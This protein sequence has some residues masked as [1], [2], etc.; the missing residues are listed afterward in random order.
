MCTQLKCHSVEV[1][2][3]VNIKSSPPGNTGLYSFLHR[4]Y[5]DV[6]LLSERRY[7]GIHIFKSLPQVHCIPACGSQINPNGTVHDQELIVVVLKRH[8][9]IQ[10]LARHDQM[11]YLY[12]PET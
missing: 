6:Y 5:M 7:I 8:F 12:T 1:N 10:T 4:L 9:L 11:G 3:Y 2:P